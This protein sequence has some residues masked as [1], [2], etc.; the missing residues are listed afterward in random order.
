MA[1]IGF[2]TQNPSRQH[3]PLAL[4]HMRRSH[5]CGA[6]TDCRRAVPIKSYRFV[7]TLK[8]N[9]DPRLAPCTPTH[10]RLEPIPPLMSSPFPIRI[11]ARQATTYLCTHQLPSTSQPIHAPQS[12]ST[13]REALFNLHRFVP[14]HRARLER[15]RL[16]SSLLIE[17]ASNH[18]RA[19]PW[20]FARGGSDQD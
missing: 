12:P 10:S 7:M 15:L 13:G 17:T 5:V 1:A 9:P 20:L 16:P 14:D 6:K 11:T 2:A 3:S 18:L 19:F 8:T 4:S